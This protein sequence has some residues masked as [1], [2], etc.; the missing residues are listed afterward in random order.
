MEIL[1]ISGQDQSGGR[2]NRKYRALLGATIVAV[3]VGLSSTLAAQI[4]INSGPVEF[5]QGVAQTVSCS[6]DASVMVTP[7][8]TFYNSEPDVVTYS[9]DMEGTSLQ[10]PSYSGISIGMVVSDG[11]RDIPEGTVVRGFDGGGWLY[12]NHAPLGVGT[13]PIT[14]TGSNGIPSTLVPT[15][16]SSPLNNSPGEY[17]GQG[18]LNLDISHLAL[19]MLVSGAGIPADTTIIYID[20]NNGGYIELSN[21]IEFTADAPLTFINSPGGGGFNLSE[22]TVSDIPTACAGKIFTVK[23]YDNESSE[24]LVLSNQN[25]AIDQSINIWWGSGYT[26]VGIHADREVVP[27]DAALFLLPIYND[28]HWPQDHDTYGNAFAVETALSEGGMPSNA[29]KIYLPTPFSATRVYKV[30]LETQDDSPTAFNSGQSY[31]EAWYD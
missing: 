5:G 2:K 4:N 10:L 20:D 29:F 9:G 28:W 26:P 7:A 3:V 13:F 8:S 27:Q 16:G 25:G 6:G 11:G 18:Y 21:T 1:N 17:Y 24:P 30:T 23:V 19:G 12:L 22:I 31:Y 15:A 14:F